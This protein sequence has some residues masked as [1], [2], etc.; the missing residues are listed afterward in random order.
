MN[1][2]RTLEIGI[3]SRSPERGL[4]LCVRPSR[5]RVR[6][7]AAAHDRGT[8]RVDARGLL[9]ISYG[10]NR[11]AVTTQLFIALDLLQVTFPC[12]NSPAPSFFPSARCSSA[13]RLSSRPGL[14]ST[15][16]AHRWSPRF[17]WAFD[18][19]F[20][21]APTLRG[22]RRGRWTERGMRPVVASGPHGFGNVNGGGWGWVIEGGGWGC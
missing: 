17:S 1:R 19:F 6:W 7:I 10:P 16:H 14:W 9:F 11:R 18:P 21:L 20:A 12:E 8:R 5:C 22:R 15:G 3:V 4:L 2:Q 13:P